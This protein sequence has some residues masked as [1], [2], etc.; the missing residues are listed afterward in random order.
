MLQKKSERLL[1]IL[2]MNEEMAKRVRELADKENRNIPGQVREFIAEALEHR[3]KS[4]G[5]QK[6]L[7]S[8]GKVSDK[9][10]RSA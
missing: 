2:R 9:K 4:E 3:S 6:R 10:E 8:S 5:V 1:G 7:L